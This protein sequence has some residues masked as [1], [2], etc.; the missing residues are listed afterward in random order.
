MGKTND[1]SIGIIDDHPAAVFGLSAFFEAGRGLKVNWT[2][3]EIANLDVKL[4]EKPVDVLIADFKIGESRILH[5]IPKESGP[6]VV[7]YS[8]FYLEENVR[9]AFGAGVM[10]WIRKSDPLADL[11]R[12]VRNAAEGRKT[13]HATD[14]QFFKRDR[15]VD[16]SDRERE[17]LQHIY[18]GRSNE[19]IA[20]LLKMQ[21]TTVK[22][23]VS[24][25]FNKLDASSRNEAVHNA[26]ARGLLSTPDSTPPSATS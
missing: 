19:E 21:V 25:L 11:E 2:V 26:I 24:H 5:W 18:Q 20:S 15:F 4:E 3:S 17:V 8:G 16:I 10:A 7:I 14:E 6:K 13:I 1:I 12:A 22:T 9:N 23:H